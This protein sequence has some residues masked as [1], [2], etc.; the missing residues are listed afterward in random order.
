MCRKRYLDDLC[1]IGPNRSYT[2]Y[3]CNISSATVLV[4]PSL[5]HPELQE[6]RMLRGVHSLVLRAASN[7]T[8]FGQ[9][10]NTFGPRLGRTR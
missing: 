2:E 9:D 1:S 8:C 5:S 3:H 10:C 6:P 4:V 7:C